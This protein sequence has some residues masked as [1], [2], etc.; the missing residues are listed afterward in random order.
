[1]WFFIILIQK[2]VFNS[3]Y[4]EFIKYLHLQ[5]KSNDNIKDLPTD[6]YN[7]KW[8]GQYYIGTMVFDKFIKQLNFYNI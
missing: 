7:K 5:Y 6:L 1:M 4:H 2:V 8:N 3:F